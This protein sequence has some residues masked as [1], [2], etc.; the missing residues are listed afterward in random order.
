LDDTARVARFPVRE[1]VAVENAIRRSLHE[2]G[3]GAP[4]LR[5]MMA[6]ARQNAHPVDAWQYT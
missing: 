2:S 4:R 5:D 6:R 1:S 3:I